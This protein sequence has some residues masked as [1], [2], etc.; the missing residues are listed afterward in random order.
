MITVKRS[1][2]D[3]QKAVQQ[4]LLSQFPGS[5]LDKDSNNWQIISTAVIRRYERGDVY[6]HGMKHQYEVHTRYARCIHDRLYLAVAN[7]DLVEKL[8]TL[9][10]EIEPSYSLK[11]ILEDEI[12]DV[13]YF[14]QVR[15][16]FKE[17]FFGLKPADQ[18]RT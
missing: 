3:V 15:K 11:V 9:I 17:F 12:E 7:Q 13:H 5:E 2:W 10:Q 6:F 1:G 8:N 4:F 14:K 16:T 18:S